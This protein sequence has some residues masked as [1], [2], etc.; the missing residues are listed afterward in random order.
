M[1]LFDL[2]SGRRVPDEALLDSWGQICQVLLQNGANPEATCGN[3]HRLPRDPSFPSGHKVS[4]AINDIFE[5]YSPFDGA[6]VRQALTEQLH[7]TPN[8]KLAL[9]QP[10]ANSELVVLGRRRTNESDDETPRKRAR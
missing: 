8:R 2:K 9:N 6:E 10:T 4:D 1:E 7:P 5:Y 3:S